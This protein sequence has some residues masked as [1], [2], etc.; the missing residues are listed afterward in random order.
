M[1]KR[2]FHLALLITALEVASCTT[3]TK[4]ETAQSKSENRNSSKSTSDNSNRNEEVYQNFDGIW[5]NE[6]YFESLMK[7][8]SPKR[9]QKIGEV[10]VLGFENGKAKINYAFHEGLNGALER[11]DAIYYLKDESGN[12]KAVT[13]SKAL[14]ELKYNKEHFKKIDVKDYYKIL[15]G[16]LFKGKYK[17]EGKEIEFTENGEIKGWADFDTYE[18]FADYYDE[19]MQVDQLSLSKKGK[20]PEFFGFRFSS[21]KLNIYDLK[22]LQMENNVCAVVENGKL[23]YKLKRV[24]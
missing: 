8:K 12:E 24:E 6:K 3:K 5:V 17:L 1:I 11:R 7:H 14:D 23:K 10:T 13:L 19:G 20:E 22:C 15:E 9:S 21:H 2:I 16:L 18:P 4:E